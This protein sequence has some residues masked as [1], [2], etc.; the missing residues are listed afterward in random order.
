VPV[1]LLQA[2]RAVVFNTSNTP[3]NREVDVFG[4]PL[5]TLWKN[6]IFDLCGVREFHRRMFEVVCLSTAQ[7]RTKWLDEVEGTVRRLFPKA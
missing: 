3:L 1:G 6:C 5:E 2:R 4:D 7:H